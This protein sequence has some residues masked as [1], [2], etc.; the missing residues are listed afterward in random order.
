MLPPEL[1]IKILCYTDLHTL[2]NYREIDKEFIENNIKYFFIKFCKNFP[3]LKY[4][5]PVVKILKTLKIF[6]I[7][8]NMK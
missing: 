6:G 3:F 1:I 2:K 4:G 7:W 5:D 8:K